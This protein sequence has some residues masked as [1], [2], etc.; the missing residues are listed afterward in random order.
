MPYGEIQSHSSITKEKNFH[1]FYQ[2][3][4]IAPL[5]L[6]QALFIE[7]EV[8]DYAYVKDSNKKIEG[9]DDLAEFK[10]FVTLWT[11]FNW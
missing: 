5:A 4:A 10:P 6:K 7:G 8:N 9:D 11:L 3:L 1:I 2:F